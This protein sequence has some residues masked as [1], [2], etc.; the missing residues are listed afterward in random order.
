M[1]RN[2]IAA[3]TRYADQEEIEPAPPQ[4]DTDAPLAPERAESAPY[5]AAGQR[6]AAA[7]IAP[8][9]HT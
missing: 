8:L 7:R 6:G 4:L 3:H 1:D 5:H 9:R 2:I